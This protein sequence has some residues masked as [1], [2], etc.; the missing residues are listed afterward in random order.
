MG[1]SRQYLYASQFFLP[2]PWQWHFSVL[3]AKI[4]ELMGLMMPPTV[5]SFLFPGVRELVEVWMMP[6]SLVGVCWMVAW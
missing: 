5:F 4:G 2:Q 1:E 6:R 3:K